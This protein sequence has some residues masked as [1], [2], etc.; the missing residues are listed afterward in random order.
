MKIAASKIKKFLEK[1]DALRGVL[2]YGSDNSKVDFYAREIIANLMDYSVQVMDFTIINKSPDLLLSELANISMFS[3]KKL[4]KLL[5]V[6]GNISK[7]LK[8]ILDRNVGDNYILMV[9]GELTY[10][11]AVKSYMEGSNSFGVIAFYKDISSNLYDII[12]N[13]LARNGILYTRELVVHLQDYFNHSRAPIY[14]E[15]E[16]LVLYLGKKQDLKLEDIEI[17]FSTSGNTYTTLDSLCSA[18]A[19]KDISNFIKTSDILLS[20]ESFQPIALIRI[21]SNY[22]LRLQ[23]VLFSTRSGISQHDAINQLNPPIF[24]KQLQSFKSDL[25]ATSLQELKKILITL[26][27]LEIMCKKTSLSQK[28]LFQQ[29]VS[30]IL[31]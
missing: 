26:M 2:I 1:P 30:E 18:V 29:K 14:P 15:L 23:N 21:I 5:N 12:S 25:Q 6:H 8:D 13:Y 19:R 11:S 4:I 17:C 3:N 31:T 7:E 27:N 20:Y 9:A 22:F 16:K 10:N 28:M 24:F